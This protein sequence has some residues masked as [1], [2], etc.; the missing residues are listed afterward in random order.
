MHIIR[1]RV[2]GGKGQG[3]KLGFSTANLSIECAADIPYGVYAAETDY[4]G[5]CYLS[6]VNIGAHPTLPE[7]PP[8]VEV[9]I[10]DQSFPLYGETLCVRLTKFIRPEKRFDTVDALRKQVQLDMD[11]VRSGQYETP[12]KY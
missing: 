8:T 4:Q 2:E 3:T 12:E 5:N 7:G 6:I 9:H 11:C 10:L 1:G